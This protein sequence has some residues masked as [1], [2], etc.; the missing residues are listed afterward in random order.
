LSVDL[1]LDDYP[2][3]PAD[4]DAWFARPSEARASARDGRLREAWLAAW[5]DVPFFADVWREHGLTRDD[6]HGAADLA[7]LPTTDIEQYRRSM[8]AHP[9]FGDV[10]STALGDRIISVLTSGGTTGFPRPVPVTATARHGAAQLAARSMGFIGVTSTDVVQV[11][12]TF[13]THGAAWIAA[14]AVD[15]LGA[16]LVPSSSGA[17]TRS[18]EQLEIMQRFDTT[19]LRTSPSYARILATTA[20]EIG[21]DPAEFG[22]RIIIT[23]GEVV[24]P[25]TRLDLERMWGAEVFDLYGT[26]ETLVWSSIDCSVSRAN[27]GS[28]GMH[29]WD[30]AIVLEVIRPDGTPCVDGEYGELTFTSWVCDVGPKFRYRMGDRVAITSEPCACGLDTPRLLPLSGRLDDCL[31]IRGQNIWPGSLEEAVRQSLPGCSDYVLVADRVDDR[32]RLQLLLNERAGTA[33]SRAAVSNARQ[34]LKAMLGVTIDVELASASAVSALNGSGANG[35]TR[36]I[37]DRRTR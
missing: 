7:R 31:R 33:I 3:R 29:I 14:W 23:A 21:L 30:D 35:K 1:A 24:S 37:V 27:G 26:M 11:T 13:S 34:R 28:G 32:D 17:V 12:S 16:T 22:V 15:L 9:P 20:A 4:V 8:A 18:R 2:W 6:L 25:Q 10:I 36:R 19:V 5:R